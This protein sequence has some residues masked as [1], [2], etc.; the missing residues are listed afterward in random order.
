M[1]TFELTSPEGKTYRIDGPDGATKDQ[2][3]QILQSRIGGA[4]SGAKK[5]PM[6]ADQYMAKADDARKDIQPPGFMDSLNQSVSEFEHHPLDQAAKASGTVLDKPFGAANVAFSTGAQFVPAFGA[7]VADMF[8]ADKARDFFDRQTLSLAP[9]TQTGRDYQQKFGD[10]IHESGIEGLAPEFGSGVNA[11]RQAPSVARQAGRLAAP[12]VDRGGDMA[13][14]AIAA[15]QRAGT[16]ALRAPGVAVDTARGAINDVRGTAIP[17]ARQAA[18][19]SGREALESA[20]AQQDSLAASEAA[21][22]QNLEK[23]RTN[24]NQHL[25]QPRSNS[26]G[27]AVPNLENQGATTDT[28]YK[29]AIKS[30]IDARKTATKPLYDQAEADGAALEASGSSPDISTARAPLFKLKTLVKDTPLESEVDGMLS[31]VGQGSKKVV[32]QPAQ[33]TVSPGEMARLKRQVMDQ[34]DAEALAGKKTAGRYDELMR[35][36][37]APPKAPEIQKTFDPRAPTAPE[38]VQGKNFKQL[39]FTARYF[40]DMQATG[41]MNG[42]S[43]EIT[44]AYGEAADAIDASL[45]QF[46]PAYE[47]ASSTY[48]K[49]SEPL[50]SLS[51]RLGKV[52]NDTE[53]GLQ[54]NRYPKT[55]PLNL[56]A[57]VFGNSVNRQIFEDAI[58]GGQ[59]VTGTARDQAKALVDKMTE[60]WILADTKEMSGESAGAHLAAPKMQATLSSVPKVAER[61]STRFEAR[62]ALEQR[63]AKLAED[64]KAAQGRAAQAKEASNKMKTDIDMADTLNAMPDAASKEKAFQGYMNA[65]ARER[66]AGLIDPAKYKATMDLVSRANTLAERTRLARKIAGRIAGLGTAVFIGSEVMK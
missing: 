30:G 4:S 12:I 3:F 55:A 58:A 17:P 42:F 64:A 56:P 1:P 27:E 41:E 45:K 37:L 48:R 54:G 6:S 19:A 50:V 36:K 35:E 20:A 60:N 32:A 52:F 39:V 28:T 57:K 18:A 8:H 25:E 14:S 59:G 63:S 23:L 29:A 44:H 15:G 34:V 49:L 16:S 11:A 38:P 46:V 33:R 2:A 40:R 66:S 51:T 21:H 26:A 61:L 53:G 9:M 5:S 62:A 10:F 65:L 47:Q 31:S 43:S 7:G 13:A 22:A 24:L